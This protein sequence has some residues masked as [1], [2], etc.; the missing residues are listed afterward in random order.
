MRRTTLYLGLSLISLIA[1]LGLGCGGAGGYGGGGGGG[2]GGSAIFSIVITPGSSSLRAGGTQQLTPACQNINGNMVSCN[3]LA[4]MSTNPSVASV[5]S[6]GL[7]TASAVGSTNVTA[8]ITYGS[9]GP[10]GMPVTY[11]SNT[12]TITVTTMDAVMGTAA[13]GR[14]LSGAL[15]TLEDARG[16][17]VSTLSASDGHF[18]LSVAGLTAPFL[19]KADDGRGQVMFGA[20]GEA[21][22][23]NVDP[24]TDTML[25]AWYGAHG[26]DPA[27]AFTA[28]AVPDAKGLALL[29][30]GFAQALQESLGSQGLDADKFSPLST[31]FDANGKGFDRLL[32][33]LTVARG[34][35][36]L[37]D[38]F[39]GRQ[40]SIDVEDHAL[41]LTTRQGAQPLA[42]V[43]RVE[44][45]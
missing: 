1:L 24:L 22:V 34:A 39:T 30:R 18:Q 35:L 25:R 2:G 12:S 17:S 3:G 31:P 16:Q 13:M 45:P 23:A 28:H 15:V 27:A 33:G 38:G 42:S 29:D 7:V 44:L 41:V 8:S 11:T 4:W 19:L 36:S 6:S 43:S 14:A 5:S 37:T 40:L 9:S 20:A 26:T 32:D 21:G 10:Y